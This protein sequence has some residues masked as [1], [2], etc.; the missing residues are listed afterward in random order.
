MA[1]AADL[2]PASPL[3][4]TPC[5]PTATPVESMN[6]EIS[7][8]WFADSSASEPPTPIGPLEQEVS[9]HL[10]P[11]RGSDSIEYRGKQERATKMKPHVKLRVLD[12]LSW[13]WW[14]EIGSLFISIA[15]LITLLGVLAGYQDRA[16]SDWHLPLQPNSVISILTTTMKTTVLLS[17]SAC[18][19]QLK[20]HHFSRPRRLNDLEAF[21][22]ASRGPWGSFLLVL[23]FRRWT[24]L[25]SGLAITTL[26]SLLVE[27]TAQQILDFPSREALMKGADVEIVNSHVFSLSDPNASN[28]S[29]YANTLGIRSTVVNAATGHISPFSFSCPDSATRCTYPAFTTLGIC[30]EFHSSIDASRQTCAREQATGIISC[31]ISV[32]SVWS[33]VGQGQPV[34]VR[35][36]YTDEASVPGSTYDTEADYQWAWDDLFVFKHAQLSIDSSRGP[37]LRLYGVRL[38]RKSLDRLE[39]LRFEG[40]ECIWYYCAQTFTTSTGSTE[41]VSPTLINTDIL[42]PTDPDCWNGT[43]T[44]E[45]CLYRN[46]STEEVYHLDGYT[47]WWLHRYVYYTVGSTFTLARPSKGE[48]YGQSGAVADIGIYLYSAPDLSKV[49]RDVATQVSN[50][51][52]VSGGQNAN[53]TSVKGLA[54]GI[55]T[56]IEVRWEWILLPVVETLL[57]VVL[58][59]ATIVVTHRSRQPLLKSSVNALLFHGLEGWTAADTAREVGDKETSQSLMDVSRNLE[60][61]FQ[62]DG[63]EGLRF[64]VV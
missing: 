55:E 20:W 38:L 33:E 58:L 45:Y 62:E 19:S 47:P 29:Y 17:V 36:N 10:S 15:S 24:I 52:R 27:P 53:T 50:I 6:R 49:F 14:W 9:S 1:H 30:S 32:P 26:V 21:D 25:A 2:V 59:A 46:N 35:L 57:A 51:M 56:Y 31:N 13:W 48:S 4:S 23:K 40:F 11:Y 34:S 54:F 22:E 3:T 8:R 44:P 18:F 43:I 63:I 7:L 28:D 39:D 61:R 64:V 5:L 60:A 41:N 37:Y 16:M 42:T 12:C